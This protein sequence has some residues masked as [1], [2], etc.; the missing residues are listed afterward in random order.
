MILLNSIRGWGIKGMFLML[1]HE[2]IYLLK[3][4]SET[5]KS[6]GYR[7]KYLKISENYNIPTPA[8]YIN[9]LKKFFKYFTDHTFVDVGSGKGRVLKAAIDLK[10][11]N[12][13][14]IEKSERLL[15]EQKEKFKNK[16]THYE[17]DADDYII[18]DT[19]KVIFYFFESFKESNFIKFIEK[20]TANNSFESFFIVLIYSQK[21]NMLS[22]YLKNFKIKYSYKF[23]TKRQIVIL[24]QI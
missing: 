14:S 4:G 21:Q 12:I 7:S 5:F 9:I 18:K 2:L 13:I 17:K 10:F 3:N 23:S 1:I 16:I 8:I 11:K 19:E 6:I 22:H 20:Q 24:K 15:T